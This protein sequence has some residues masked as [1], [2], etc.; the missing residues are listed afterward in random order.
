MLRTLLSTT[1]RRQ[2][3][4]YGAVLAVSV[5]AACD[6]T[7]PTSA[8]EPNKPNA[9]LGGPIPPS[10]ISWKVLDEKNAV[11]KYYGAKFQLTGPFGLSKIIDDN[12]QSDSDLNVGQFKL[13]GLAAGQYTICQI[14]VAMGFMMP[15]TTPCFS[16]YLNPGGQLAFTFFNPRPPYL[17]WSAVNDVGT[18]LGGGSTFTV[19]DSLGSVRTITDG[20]ALS[21]SDPWPGGLQTSV[22]HPGTW[23]ICETVPPAGYVKPAGQQ[24]ANVVV[25]WGDIGWGGQFANNFPYSLNFG[26]TEG[27]LDLNNNYVPLGGATFTVAYQ[28]GLSKTTVVDNGANDYDPRP[29]RIAVKLGAA[30]SYTVCETQAPANHWLPKPPCQSVTVSYATPAFVG[31]FITPESQVIYNP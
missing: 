27:V 8:F 21:D 6:K 28:R 31:W 24:C 3:G 14:N 16:G 1:R 17:Q 11:V 20:D 19:K 13:A 23:T 25:N 5:L 22:G 12:D 26:V 15:P 4:V 2:L 7:D 29:G 18:M 10:I 9:S 30:G